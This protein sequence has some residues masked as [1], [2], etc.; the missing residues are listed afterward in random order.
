MQAG[1]RLAH[2]LGRVAGQGETMAA[3]GGGQMDAAKKLAMKMRK[4]WGCGTEVRQ[5]RAYLQ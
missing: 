1:L 2:G 3:G 4:K 5:R